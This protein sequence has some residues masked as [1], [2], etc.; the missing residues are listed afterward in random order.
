MINT[1]DDIILAADTVVNS[2]PQISDTTNFWMVRSKQGVF[3]NEYVAGGYIAIGWNS[4]TKNNLSDNRD[5]DYYKQTLKDNDY[6][7]KMPGTALNKCRRFIEEIKPGDIAMIVGRSEITFATIGDYFE[8]DLDTATPEKELEVHK[9]IETGTYLGLNCPYKKRRHISIISKVDLGSAPPMVYKCLVSN[10]HSLS[11]LNEY[12]DAILSCCYDLSVYANRLIIKYH[13]GQAKDINPFDFSLFT[14]SMADLIADNRRELTGRYNLNS[15][16]DVVFFLTN[17]GENIFPFLKDHL[18][19]I[20]LG[21][22]ILFGG[23]AAGIEFP[24]SIEKIKELV[25]DFLYRKE[26]KRIKVAEADKAEAEAEKAKV[27]AERAR[28]ELEGLKKDTQRK[29]DE[30]VENLTRAAAP[31]NIRPPANSIIDITALFQID[32]ETE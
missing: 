6:P 32:D 4:L 3:Y 2:V 9:Q 23:K 5:D 10:R 18:V 12:A 26:T 11:S 15:E 27:D 31:L 1:L 28:F 14:L 21:Y 19:P 8:V 13:I 29:A 17:F 22:F 25:A 30:T 24:S 20:I 16:G 7:D